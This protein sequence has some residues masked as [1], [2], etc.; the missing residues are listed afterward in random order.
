MRLLAASIA[1]GL[2]LG[3]PGTAEAQLRNAYGSVGYQFV[4]AVRKRDTATMLDFVRANGS[5]MIN[6][7]DDRGESAMHIVTVQRNGEWLAYFLAQGGDPNLANRTG[8]TP[9]HL[10][11][12]SGW[13]EGMELLL[14]RKARVDAANRLGE[15]PL[16][17]AVQQRQLGAVRRLLEAGADPNRT[18]NASGRSARDYAK[19]DTRSG[20]EILQLL[21]S[22]KPAAAK[23]VAGPKL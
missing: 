22:V 21:D 1:L 3:M 14:R 15:T 17:I 10:A 18:D 9:L 6:F 20:R 7:R 23:P 2:A 19:L 4:E 8:D 5:A 13:S 12:R 11:A 16:I